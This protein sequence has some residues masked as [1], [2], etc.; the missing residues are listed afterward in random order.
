MIGS[1]MIKL[2]NQLKF[3]VNLFCFTFNSNN[4]I[5]PVYL[6]EPPLGGGM[7]AGQQKSA[8]EE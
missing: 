8:K 7:R 4:A 2:E 3:L 6:K 5:T 1:S